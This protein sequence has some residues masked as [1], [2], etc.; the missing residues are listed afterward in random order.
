MAGRV[1]LNTL[2]NVEGRH[3]VDE[4]RHDDGL[5]LWTDRQVLEERE[6]SYASVL[7]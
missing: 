6:N 3:G 2:F 1:R 7:T 4:G 5:V